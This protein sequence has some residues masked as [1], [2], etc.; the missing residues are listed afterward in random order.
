[1]SLTGPAIIVLAAALTVLAAVVTARR[2]GRG[3]RRRLPARAAG[4]LATEALLALTIGLIANRSERFYPSWQT[5]AGDG[6]APATQAPAPV[7]RLDGTLTPGT[8]L[9]W[10]PPEA[11]RWRL[12]GPPT[13]VTPAGYRLAGDAAFPVVVLLTSAERAAAARAQAS[14]ATDVLTVVAVPTPDTTAAALATLPARLARD[15]RAADTGWA[16]VADPAHTALAR[17]WRDLLPARFRT[18][19]GSLAAAVDQLPAALAPP[20]RLPS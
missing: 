11:A 6:P 2:W 17:Q 5:L 12:D 14:A 4:L 16:I 18:V 1:M 8:A 3:G 15:A 10:S 19:A 20:L 13:L 9:A 7:G